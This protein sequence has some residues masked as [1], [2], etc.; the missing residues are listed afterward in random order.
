[1]AVKV[2]VDHDLSARQTAAILKLSDKTRREPFTPQQ[3]ENKNIIERNIVIINLY[4]IILGN[5]N[6]V[7]TLF[8]FFAWRQFG[9]MQ[10]KAL[11]CTSEHNIR[12]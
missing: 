4:I 11:H 3:I 2:A 12:R 6:Y 10:N 5:Y 1:M 7:V 9:I 8:S